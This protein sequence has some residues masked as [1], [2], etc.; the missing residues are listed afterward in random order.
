MG[1]EV[2][3]RTKHRRLPKKRL[4]PG[5]VAGPLPAPVTPVTRDG[6]LASGEAVLTP[7]ISARMTL[8]AREQA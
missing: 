7:R 3:A 5:A 4:F 1:Q 2:T 8:P 6:A